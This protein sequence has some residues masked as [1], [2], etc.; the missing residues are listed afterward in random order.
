MIVGAR[1][2]GGEVVAPQ[3]RGGASPLGSNQ[4]RL[5]APRRPHAASWGILPHSSPGHDVLD[6][7]LPEGVL[8]ALY[9]LRGD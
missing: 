5:A 6:R 1:H 9:E 4:H 8:C 7:I 3:G 2:A